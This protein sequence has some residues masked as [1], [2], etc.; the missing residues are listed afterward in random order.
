MVAKGYLLMSAERSTFSQ[1]ARANRLSIAV[2]TRAGR[3][4]DEDFPGGG[5]VFGPDGTCLCATPN[6]AEGVLDATID[7]E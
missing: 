2:A 7:P 1:Y 5:Y 3:T 6:G 4:C